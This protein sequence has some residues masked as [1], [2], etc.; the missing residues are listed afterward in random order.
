M[1]AE[2]PPPAAPAAAAAPARH[3]A[4]WIALAAS[5]ASIF[6]TLM[7]WATLRIFGAGVSVDGIDTD[8]GKIALA[9]AALAVVASG[10]TL[11]GRRR[12]SIGTL[13]VGVA[14]VALAIYEIADIGSGGSALSVGSGLYV[15]VAAGIA[16]AGAGAVA[17]FPG[18][19]GR[20]ATA[21][22]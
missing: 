19:L 14:T 20:R 9:L 16:L 11:A 8:D 2:Q 6:S 12:W 10:L 5:V 7:P 21:T 3:P 4:G 15:M 18:R 1:S 17:A 22:G 13:A